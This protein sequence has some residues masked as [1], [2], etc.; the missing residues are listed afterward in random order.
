L[1]FAYFGFADETMENC[2]RASNS[3]AKR[4]GYNECGVVEVQFDWVRLPLLFFFS[5]SCLFLATSKYHLSSSH[6]S[7]ADTVST[8]GQRESDDD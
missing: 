2:R 7:Y 1:F 3:V 8:N 4:M 6:G 5:Y